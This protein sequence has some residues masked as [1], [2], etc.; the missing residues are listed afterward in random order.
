MSLSQSITDTL[1]GIVGAG[2]VL[3]QPEDVIPYGFDGTAVLRQ[4]PAV[5][6]FPRTAEEVSRCVQLAAA[7]SIPIVTRGS[8]TG[9]SGGSVPSVGSLVLCLARMNAILDVDPRN[10]TIRAQ[11]GAVTLAID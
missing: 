8:G 7:Q 10:L 9:L 4:V 2:S 1:T 5:V 3:T 6:V 11:P